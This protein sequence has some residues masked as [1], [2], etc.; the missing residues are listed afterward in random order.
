M[1]AP[2][3]KIVE[4]PRSTVLFLFIFL[5][6]G[7]C[8]SKEQPQKDHPRLSPKVAMTDVTF[9]SLALG[10]EMPYRIVMPTL[11]APGQK[12]PVVYLLHGGGGGYR[13][14]TNYS[15]VAKYAERGLILVMPEGNSSYYTNSAEHPEDRYEDYI[16]NDV[17]SEVESKYPVALGRQNRAIL[18]V[19]MGGYGAVKNAMKHPELFMFA[20]GLSAAV[21]VPTRPFSI[22]RMSQWRFHSSIFGAS[23][24]QTRHDNDPYALARSV[25]PSRTPYLFLTCGEQE[26]LLPANRKL[27]AILAE[28]DFKYE[29][30]T[31]PGDH[32]WLQW[33]A[34]LPNVFKSLQERIGPAK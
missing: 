8:G 22:K 27:N 14:W 1:I 34:Q 15:D 28:R 24:S 9:R 11:I 31:A 7:G 23:G 6:L 5:F 18:G 10:R 16:V 21:D 17:I 20:G 4:R 19:S 29:F 25:D 2:S 33:N 26:G 32:N 3:M 30:H 12:L 13:D